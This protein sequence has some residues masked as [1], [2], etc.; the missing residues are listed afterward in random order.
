MAWNVA[1]PG[2]LPCQ[3]EREQ[4]SRKGHL[5]LSGRKGVRLR[6]RSDELT[7]QNGCVAKE[8]EPRKKEDAPQERTQTS[9]QGRGLG[10]RPE[11]GGRGGPVKDG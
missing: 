7:P 3:R 9:K 11:V 4:K 1:H 6:K 8:K 5:D 2:N 10:E